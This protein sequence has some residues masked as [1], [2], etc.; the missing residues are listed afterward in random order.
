MGCRFKFPPLEH[1][2]KHLENVQHF[3]SKIKWEADSDSCW[4]ALYDDGF[5]DVG[6]YEYYKLN[7]WK[8]TMLTISISH[9]NGCS[10]LSLVIEIWW[11]E[12]SISDE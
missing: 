2:T 4:N 11:S 1:G 6:R 3:F 5:T 8:A 9:A 7:E 10:L 12:P